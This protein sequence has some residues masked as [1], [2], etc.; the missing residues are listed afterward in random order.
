MMYFADKLHLEKYGRFICGDNYVAMKHGPVPSSTYDLLKIVRDETLKDNLTH[1]A[2][3]VQDKFLV[4]PLRTAN[5]DYFSE[6][7]LE[8]L[9]N[10]IKKYG[11][12][13]FNL[14]TDLSHDKAWQAADENDCI[15]IEQIVATLVNTGNLLDYLRDPC[16]G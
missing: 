4:K 14:L 10:T 2:F 15:D 1:R 16:P 13:S 9:D 12:L 5:L 11:H 8:C 7:D 3:T 6:S